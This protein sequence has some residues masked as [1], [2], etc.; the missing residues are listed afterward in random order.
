MGTMVSVCEG[1]VI[2]SASMCKRGTAYKGFA[3][4]VSWESTRTE[5][6]LRMH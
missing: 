3:Q 2:F 1:C 6:T 4:T 5:A